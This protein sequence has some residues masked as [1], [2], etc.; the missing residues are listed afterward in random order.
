MLFCFALIVDKDNIFVCIGLKPPMLYLPVWTTHTNLLLSDF[1][2]HF[3]HR[4]SKED[5]AAGILENYNEGKSYKDH[6]L[7]E[8]V[9]DCKP[10]I[11]PGLNRFFSASKWFVLCC[12]NCQ[13]GCCWE[14][15]SLDFPFSFRE[16]V[17]FDDHT[18]LD[19]GFA[20]N[21]PEVYSRRWAHVDCSSFGI[22][23]LCWQ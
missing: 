21:Y 22:C 2:S 8:Y 19:F 20:L 23:C 4:I 11:M 3:S 6:S 9:K 18:G 12:Y 17:S 10:E 15:L 1:L 7:R 16:I 5:R 13:Y 14:H